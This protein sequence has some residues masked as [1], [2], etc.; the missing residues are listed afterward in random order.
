MGADGVMDHV[1]KDIYRAVVDD[2]A[3]ALDQA[4]ER[5]RRVVHKDLLARSVPGW[6]RVID[7]LART[8]RTCDVR[9]RESFRR[10]V[11]HLRRQQFD[12]ALLSFAQVPQRQGGAV[13]RDVVVRL[14]AERRARLRRMRSSPARSQ[15][16]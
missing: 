6:L 13:Y 7:T 10:G 4:R 3:R 9:A 14:M 16:P 11:C 12:Q 5:V 8:R 1:T 2:D 15:R